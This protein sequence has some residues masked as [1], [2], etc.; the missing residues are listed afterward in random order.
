MAMNEPILTAAEALVGIVSFVLVAIAAVVWTAER[1][2]RSGW[3]D[4]EQEAAA[5]RAR[6]WK[7]LTENHPEAIKFYAFW[8]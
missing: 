7:Q 2:Y 1:Y 8:R 3:Q 4:A 6:A 5:R